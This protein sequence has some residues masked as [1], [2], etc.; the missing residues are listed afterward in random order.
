MF[1]YYFYSPRFILQNSTPFNLKFSQ[2]H[3]VFGLWERDPANFVA[4][5]SGSS[6][7][8]HW[9]DSSKPFLLCA[10]ASEPI[11]SRW[12]G[13]FLINQVN[14]SYLNLRVGSTD[15]VFLEVEVIYHSAMFFV[16]IRDLN[17][18]PPLIRVDNLSAVP[19]TVL[20]DGCRD[21]S[22]RCEIP[23][24]SSLPYV[25]DEPALAEVLICQGELNIMFKHFVF[26]S[27]S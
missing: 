5:P 1:W 8:F 4:A 2:Q 19:V 25:F 9:T 27:I 21:A 10:R 24:E 13:G 11:S 23:S 6:C 16:Q 26:L 12:S 3:L 17:G 15:L 14:T 20:Q 22:V 18:I 7:N